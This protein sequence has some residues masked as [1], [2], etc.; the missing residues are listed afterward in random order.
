MAQLNDITPHELSSRYRIDREIGRG[1]MGLVF[2]AHDR[3]TGDTV[4]IKILRPELI[5]SVSAERFHREI[6]YLRRLRH[7]NI[8]PLLDSGQDRDQVYFTMPFVDGDTL[9]TRIEQAGP[10]SLDTSLSIIAQLAGALDYAHVQN[11]LHR[12]LKP[13]NVLFAGENVVLCDFGVARAIVASSSEDAISSSGIVVGTPCYMSPEQAFGGSVV[14]ARSDIYA[15]GCV[16]YEMLIGEPPFHGASLFA[17]MARHIT[18]PPRPM[19][20]VRPEIPP[21]IESAVHSAMAKDVH[22][23]P[24]S[25]SAFVDRLRSA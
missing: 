13:E 4:A 11:V 25:A 20:S 24:P 18:D 1:A 8:L 14:D 6:R 17:I 12:D 2:K 22:A 7:P 19:R 3:E 10:F 9:R 16:M 21:H 15:L 23:R 5:A